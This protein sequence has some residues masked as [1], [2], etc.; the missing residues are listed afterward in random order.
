MRFSLPTAVIAA[1]LLLA[2]CGSGAGKESP[3][4]GCIT[5]AGSYVRAL[6][7]DPASP[8]LDD[9]TPISDCL[10]TGQSGGD[11]ADVGAAIIEASGDL[12]EEARKDPGGKANFALGYLLGVVRDA[13]GP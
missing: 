3:P 6:E 13:G 12:N 7:A 5:G 2:G 11:Q 1:S 4:I 9:G 10:P 8:A